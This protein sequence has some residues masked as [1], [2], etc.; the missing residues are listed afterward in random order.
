MDGYADS[1]WARAS[2]ERLCRLSLALVCPVMRR[3]VKELDLGRAD[4]WMRARDFSRL[5]AS[6]SVTHNI[7]PSQRSAAGESV[8]SDIGREARCWRLDRR[9][10]R[11]AGVDA[12]A[13]EWHPQTVSPLGHLT[14]KPRFRWRL[15]CLHLRWLQF[16]YRSTSI[17]FTITSSSSS[18]CHRP[19]EY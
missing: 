9:D 12:L 3:L 15:T 6:G 14:S 7:T 11:S 1:Y 18:I 5:F 10:R 17:V 19:D 13:R 2:M 4:V 16:E 8:A